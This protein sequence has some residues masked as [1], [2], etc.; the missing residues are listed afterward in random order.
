MIIKIINKLRRKK[1]KKQM[2][3]VRISTKSYKIEDPNSTEEYYK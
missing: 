2:N 1:K 3:T